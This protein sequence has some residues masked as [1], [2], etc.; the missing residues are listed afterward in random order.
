MHD[1]IK[2]KTTRNLECFA[3]ELLRSDNFGLIAVY[4]YDE[5]RLKYDDESKA[6]IRFGKQFRLS[7]DINY[8]T[9]CLN[10]FNDDEIY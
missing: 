6:C 8:L 5:K 3:E 2:S 1:E 10:I 7:V 4:W 9:N